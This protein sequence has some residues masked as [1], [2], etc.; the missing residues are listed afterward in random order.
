MAIAWDSTK[1]N[2]SQ[3]T[4]PNGDIVYIK[5]KEARDEIDKLS[6]Y[7]QFLG[8]TTTAIEDGTASA[9]VAIGGKDV[10]AKKGDIVIYNKV[11]NAGTLQE[12]TVA[13][14]FIYDGE[15][16]SLFGDLSAAA[17]WLGDLAYNDTASADYTPEGSVSV[18][19]NPTNATVIAQ[20][21][22][23]GTAPSFE[24][25][26]ATVIGQVTN[27][28]TVPTFEATEATVLTG[29]S[30]A[31]TLPTFTPTNAS[32][33]TGVS[34]AGTLPTF[35]STSTEVIATAT[36]GTLPAFSASLLTA[37]VNGENLIFTL[38]ENGFS[39]GTLPSFTTSNVVATTAFTAGSMPT[40]KEG[41]VIG[42]ATFTQ[43]AMPTFNSGSVVGS[44]TFDAGA[45]PTFSNATVVGSTT[46]SAGAMPTFSSTSVLSGVT[47]SS[48][49][50]SGTASTIT[51][52]GST[53]APTV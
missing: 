50:F 12:R 31:G 23:E 45:M 48:A 49:T 13:Q 41:E 29:V 38:A 25:T 33:L 18:V 14:E 1:N 35:T 20:V 17:N 22:D 10:T 44:T 40:F 15:A 47:V 3:V 36:Q 9:V 30:T 32:V 4:L 37:S 7:T 11:F 39:A 26:E 42:S 46:F 24:A 5:D 53:S 8:V 43:G 21:T 28:G 51:V 16:W 19:L 27:G 34:T 52:S 2:I 6:A